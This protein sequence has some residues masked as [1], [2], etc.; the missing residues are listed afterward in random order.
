MLSLGDQVV[1]L[2]LLP[3]PVACI[4]WTVTHEEV[5]KEVHEYCTLRATK[6]KTLVGRKFYYLLTCEF[7]FSHYVTI[8]MLVLTRY[9][10]LMPDWR[11]Y[12]IGG[13]AVVWIAN[14]YMTIYSVLRGHMKKESIETKLVEKESSM[15]GWVSRMGRSAQKESTHG[16]HSRS[17]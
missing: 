15:T 2:F 14:L 3:I 7:C 11:G 1:W 13:F 12:L 6:A 17:K 9:K 5:F 8:A 4:A 10:M 16:R